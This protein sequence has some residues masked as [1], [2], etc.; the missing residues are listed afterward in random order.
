MNMNKGLKQIFQ[1]H[2][3]KVSDKWSLYLDEWDRLF[4]EFKDK[5]INL[6]EIGIQNGGSLEVWS[7]YFQKAR[8]I[9]GCDID[10]KCELLK[11]NDD[12]IT[13][14][15]GNANSDECEK[16]IIQ[17]ASEFGIIIEDASHYS[18]EIVRS[19]ARYFPYL[20]DGGIYIVEDLHF[21][22]WESYEGGLNNPFSAMVFFKRLADLVNYEHWRNKKPRESLLAEFSAKFGVA[23]TELD[24]SKIHSIELINSLCIIKKMPREKNL[25][26]RRVVV[27]EDEFVTTGGEELTGTAVQ[28]YAQKIKDDAAL[29]VFELIEQNKKLLQQVAEKEHSLQVYSAQASQLVQAVQAITSHSSEQEKRLE[30]L[31]GQ[32]KEISTS[33]AWHAVLLLRRVWVILLPSG[34]LRWRLARKMRPLLLYP[35]KLRRTYKTNQDLRLI[36]KSGFFDL[37]W[38]LARNFDVVNANIDPVSHYLFFG[39]SEGRDPGPN[40]SSAA[41]LAAYEDVKKAG[42]N[43]LVH[44]LRN[45]RTEGRLPISDVEFSHLTGTGEFPSVTIVHS[46]NGSLPDRKIQGAKQDLYIP[47]PALQMD[48][49]TGL[50]ERV[51]GSLKYTDFLVSISQDDYLTTDFGLQIPISDEQALYAER[52]ISYIHLYSVPRKE[53]FMETDAYF[54]IGLNVDSV[55]IGQYALND[56]VMLLKRLLDENHICRSL[57]LHHFK[58]WNLQALNSVLSAI[59]PAHTFFTIQDYF[60]ACPQPNLLRNQR[61]FCNAPHVESNSCTICESGGIRKEHLH[62]VTQLFSAYPFSVIAPTRSAEDIWK[63]VFPDHTGEIRVVPPVKLKRTPVRLPIYPNDPIRIA[64]AGQDV[65]I[66]G[67]EA[68]RLLVDKSAVDDLEFFHLGSCAGKHRETF[69]QVSTSRQNRTAMIDALLRNRIDVLF[70][71]PIYPEPFSFVFYEAMAAGCFVI[72][73]NQTGDVAK[74]VKEQGNGMV[75]ERS[76]AM[77]AYLSDPATL[78]NDLLDFRRRFPNAFTLE[79]NSS[80]A[81]LVK[82]MLPSWSQK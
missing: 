69:E 44:Y 77:L 26:G 80:I 73:S 43:P 48:P 38:Y 3:G 8:K 64:Y 35:L 82:P 41:Y 78:R 13:V 19:F 11:F 28:D 14:I 59:Q 27:G 30:E 54:A 52:K 65:R 75:F 51:T 49:P 31:E 61:E 53:H 36:R 62:L 47:L 58:G 56:I 22:Y 16:K 66:M 79:T 4:E 6:L 37:D 7:E 81:D 10:L 34:S 39:G 63:K 32:Y 45:G 55:P 57:N 70:F 2:K 40:F 74:H 76:E 18:S 33:K 17:Q 67:W 24:L 15:V 29:D 9:I 1:E 42:I 25:L 12:R 5:K 60:F 72:T 20:N 68:W 71:W 23:F 21:S 46:V 50:W